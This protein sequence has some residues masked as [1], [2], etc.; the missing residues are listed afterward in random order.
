M[1][2]PTPVVGADPRRHHGDGGRVSVAR[3]S[4][5][6]ST[7]LATPCYV[8]AV[9]RRLRRLFAATIAIPDRHQE[10]LAYSTVSQLGYM[11][12]GSGRRRVF[13]AVFHVMTHAFFKAL[14]FLVCRQ[15]IIH[16][17]DGEQDIAGWAAWRRLPITFRHDSTAP[18]RFAGAPAVRFLHQ[19]PD[20]G[21]VHGAAGFAGRSAAASSPPASPRST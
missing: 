2:G 4:T 16:A 8:V 1:V 18:P 10:R 7:S 14:L 12:L 6:S 9:V 17:L 3:V 20:P 5:S 19:R 11:F 21:H 15:S 13:A